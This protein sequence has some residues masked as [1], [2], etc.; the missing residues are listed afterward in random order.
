M[1]T[2]SKIVVAL[3]FV[4][5]AWFMVSS[6]KAITGD[7]NGDGFVNGEDAA[8]LGQ[9]FGSKP[10]DASWNPAADLNG[11]GFINAK[12]VMLLAA[13]WTS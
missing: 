1:K 6:V 7:L 10:T 12:D 3:M 4:C 8:L 9:A 13:N 5:A 11:D 2:L